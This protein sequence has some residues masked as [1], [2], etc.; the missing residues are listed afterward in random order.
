MINI[1]S[2]SVLF[3]VVGFQSREEFQV[4]IVRSLLEDEVTFESISF[5]GSKISKQ[6]STL[7]AFHVS[8]SFSRDTA[9]LLE[10]KKFLFLPFANASSLVTTMMH[11]IDTDS[12]SGFFHWI[13]FI[14]TKKFFS[15][16]IIETGMESWTGTNIL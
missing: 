3:S 2:A 10:Q 4:S 7:I 5:S 6:Y 8:Q 16:K 11:S 15:E 1:I 14:W 9:Y 12:H 13:S